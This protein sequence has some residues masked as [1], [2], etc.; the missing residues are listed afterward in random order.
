MTDTKA[1]LKREINRLKKEVENWKTRYE[2][3]SK[4]CSA[5]GPE[6]A[7]TCCEHCE[8][9]FCDSCIRYCAKCEKSCCEDCLE[10]DE[11]CCQT[12]SDLDKRSFGV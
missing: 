3:T 12:R 5:C 9:Y 1:A 8:D 11:H 7:L 2:L 10:Q 6:Y 4:V